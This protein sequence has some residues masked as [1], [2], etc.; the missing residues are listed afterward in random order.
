[1]TEDTTQLRIGEL[2]RRS[3]A[4]T[5]VLRSW[6]RRYGL[7]RPTR[8]PNGYRLYSAEDLDRALAMQAHLAAGTSAAEAAALVKNGSETEDASH[9]Q[10]PE[11]LA[12][13]RSALAAYDGAGAA[14]VLDRCLLNLGLARA[15]QLVIL[16]CL[17]D[18]GRQWECGEI[19]VAQEHFATHV[20]RRRLLTVAEGWEA[21]GD[22]LALLACAPGE[23]H[24]IGL[25]CFGLA[26]NSYHGWRIAF[27]GA[28]TP[29]PGLVHAVESMQPDLVVVSAI[30]AARFFPELGRWQDVAEGVSLAVGGAGA[31]ARL[32]K[33]I[34]AA[35][36]A[37][38]PVAA[39]SR[40]AARA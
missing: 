19:T 32:A 30:S 26:L 14:H 20:I 12:R 13:L 11:F 23:Q 31:D 28:D 2:S 36:L 27:L 17:R 3:G 10:V 40:A 9:H 34:G 25:I 21:D 8:S 18:V 24:D 35:Y 15:I 37:G 16:P 4:S 5:D 6:E 39:A 38:D 33:R 7:L 1:M 29:L 22:P